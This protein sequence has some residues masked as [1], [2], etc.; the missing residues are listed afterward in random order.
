MTR[1]LNAR[2]VN[3]G[4]VIGAV[5]AIGAAAVL[6]VGPRQVALRQRVDEQRLRDLMTIT[7]AVDAFAGR[8]TRLPA[9]LGE[10]ASGSQPAVKTQDPERQEPYGYRITGD[11]TYE[12]C[13]TFSLGAA[14]ADVS[15]VNQFWSHD[16]GRK[17][18]ALQAGTR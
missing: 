16:A 5:V 8:H 11:R 6:F 17:C 2:Q 9:S 4:V 1:S 18:Y 7:R 10:L 12:V 13:A 3:A 15:A 14:A